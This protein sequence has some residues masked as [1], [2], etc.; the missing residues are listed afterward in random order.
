[1]GLAPFGNPT[2]EQTKQYINIILDKLCDVADDGSFVLNQEY[3]SYVSGLKMVHEKKWEALFGFAL[4][5]PESN[6]EQH[7]CNLASAIQQV[8]EII[9]SRLANT[10]L[11]LT[12][13]HRLCLAGGVALNCV[14]N[15]K[16]LHGSGFDDIY[17]QPAAGD[18]GGAVGAALSAY[19]IYFSQSRKP[20]PGKD[21]MKGSYLGPIF[22]DTYVRKMAKKSKA[23]FH[24]LPDNTAL[25]L[26][27]ATLLSDGK[28]TGWFQGRMEFGPRALGNR[29]ILANPADK[30]MQKKL[31]LKIKYRESFRPFAPVCKIET[32]GKYFDLQ[33]ASPYMLF[34]ALIKKEWQCEIPAGYAEYS[35][36]EKL[37]TIRSKLPAITHVDFSCRVQTITKETNSLL[38]ELLDVFESITGHGVLINTS[39]NVRGEPIVCTPEDAYHCFM[40]TEMD[41]LVI[42]KFIFY[43]WEQPERTTP[44]NTY[45]K[46]LD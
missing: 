35:I 11:S 26:Q 46:A 39:F 15:G 9:V 33:T 6:I 22:D 2:S 18:A 42:D 45:S 25:L 24:F 13:M 32:A 14:A 43:K 12:G 30:E 16:L 29:S 23:S 28:I 27:V 20:F 40:N 4:R 7:H 36:M 34:T 19:H 41:V 5:K 3:F 21:S 1:M 38:W 44:S 8:T 10:A 17:I 37:E 31:N